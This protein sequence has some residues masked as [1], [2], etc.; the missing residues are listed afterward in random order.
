MG[1]DFI[2]YAIVDRTVVPE[3]Q[4]PFFSEKLIYLPDCF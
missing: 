4:Q 3:E 2:D 1:A